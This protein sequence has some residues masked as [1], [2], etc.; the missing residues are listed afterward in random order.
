MM[1][2][3]KKRRLYRWLCECYEG[4]YPRPPRWRKRAVWIF[5]RLNKLEVKLNAKL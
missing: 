1:K 4:A 2:K 5:K 3:H